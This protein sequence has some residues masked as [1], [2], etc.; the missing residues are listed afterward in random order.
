MKK[1]AE[2]SQFPEDIFHIENV[3]DELN[4][5]NLKAAIQVLAD[6][7]RWLKTVAGIPIGTIIAYPAGAIPE[8]FLKCN[9]AAVAR[10]SYPD[11]FAA[12]G[13]TYNQGG[14]T[15]SQFR[16]PDLRGEFIRGADEGRGIDAG[17]G[18]GTWQADEFKS[19][20]HKLRVQV[21]SDST[22]AGLGGEGNGGTIYNPWDHDPIQP[23]GGAETRPRNVAMVYCIKAFHG[24]T[25][26]ALVDVSD[27]ANQLV[28]QEANHVKYADFTGGNQSL[29]S[30]GF[31]KLPGGLIIQWG[32]DTS[33][34][35]KTVVFPVSFVSACHSVQATRN[36]TKVWSYGNEVYT[37]SYTPSSFKFEIS[38]NDGNYANG[39][40]V[41]WL[42]IGR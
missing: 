29:G 28:E 26:A 1:I 18:I 39:Y 12:I 14:E 23:T 3:I 11:L 17:R 35:S 27:L 37:H 25:N 15:T 36:H 31:Q 33:L 32:V 4:E 16:L 40:D 9:G 24:A 42:A 13:T 8:G 7:T 5:A 2:T 19:H 22:Y 21:Y 6:R 38:A 30:P 41:T 20:I 10:A 34:N